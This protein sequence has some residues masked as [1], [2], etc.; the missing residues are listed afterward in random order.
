MRFHRQRSQPVHAAAQ[1]ATHAG[2]ANRF[3]H[4]QAFEH[5]FARRRPVRA[6]GAAGRANAARSALQHNPGARGLVSDPGQIPRIQ[7]FIV[8]QAGDL[9]GVQFLAGS[10]LD[11]LRRL[12]A[13]RAQRVGVEPQLHAG[14]FA[15]RE[16]G[17]A[18]RGG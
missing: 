18:R 13:E 2:G 9:N 16:R 15:R 5:A 7:A 11:Q 8:A 17:S 10:V 14:P 6:E 4:A 3:G 12:P 1:V